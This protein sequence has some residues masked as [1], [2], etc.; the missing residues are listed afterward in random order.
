MGNEELNPVSF[1]DMVLILLESRFPW[2]GN[3]SEEAVSGA[4]TVE[5]LVELHASLLRQ[6]TA[7]DRLSRS[8][9]PEQFIKRGR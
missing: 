6:P 7:R 4:D 5:A 3:P 1:V 8:G 2:L 9:L